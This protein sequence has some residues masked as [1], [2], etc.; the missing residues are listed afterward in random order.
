MKV[1]NVISKQYLR[2]QVFWDVVY[3]W[4]SVFIDQLEAS[5]FIDRQLPVV[6][7]LLLRFPFLSVLFP[8]YKGSFSY[9]LG[10]W[11]DVPGRNKSNIIPCIVDFFIRKPEDLQKFYKEYSNHKLVLVS[12]LEV[13]EFL[14]SVNCPLHIEHLGLSLADKY[15]LTDNSVFDK[16]YDIVI[17]GRAN[18]VLMEYLAQF[19]KEYPEV[20]IVKSKRVGDDFLCFDNS[21]NFVCE[22]NT[23]EEYINILK[24]A[25]CTLYSTP[26]IDGGESRTQG[27]NQV[28]PKFLEAIACGCNIICRY[29][30]NPD[31]QFYEMEKYWPNI[32]SYSDFKRQTEK[33]LSIPFDLTL[34]I[35]YLSN[36]YTSVRVKQLKQ[37]LQ[38]I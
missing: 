23:R 14:E 2:D 29:K 37:L 28:T 18:R 7:G 6:G 11:L 9:E 17:I 32:D 12:S 38:L 36:H 21:D 16:K 10:P 5:L 19:K 25:K 15:R 31:T 1:K 33:A 24:R 22:V 4:E 30:S 3:E 34:G 20:T 35:K 8:P 13:K 26:G 27:F